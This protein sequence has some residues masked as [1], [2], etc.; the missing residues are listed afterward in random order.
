VLEFGEG[1]SST[2]EAEQDAPNAR[3]AEGSIVVLKVPT[4]GP[5]EAKDDAAKE[6]KLEKN[7]DNVR[8]CEPTSRGRIV[9]SVKG[10]CR[11]SQE[12]EDGQRA[13]CCHGDH[14]SFDPCSY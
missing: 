2:A 3:N 4:V 1:T 8:N 12:K 11:N 10:S 7:S 5:T 9:E 14:K 13:R 6:P